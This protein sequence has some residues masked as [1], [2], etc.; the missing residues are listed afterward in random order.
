MAKSDGDESKAKARYIEI[1]VG[2]MKDFVRAE[3]KKIE[4]EE[5]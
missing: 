3:V 1:R 2:E 5:E 4:E